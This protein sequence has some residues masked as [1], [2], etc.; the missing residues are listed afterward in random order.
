MSPVFFAVAYVALALC[1]AAMGLRFA[2]GPTLHDRLVSVESATI[3]LLAGMALWAL[4]RDNL[5]LFDV[6]LVIALVGFLSTVAVARF[7]EREEEDHDD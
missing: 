7:A 5:W 4:E 3:A 2:L 1:L 6:I